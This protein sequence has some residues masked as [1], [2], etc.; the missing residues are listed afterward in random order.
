LPISKAEKNS[1]EGEVGVQA[2]ATEQASAVDAP[3]A[4]N[5]GN[6]NAV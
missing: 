6:G 5:T 4:D 1:Q 2:N 3:V